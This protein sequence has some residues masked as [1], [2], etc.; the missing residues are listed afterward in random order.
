MLTKDGKHKFYKLNNKEIREVKYVETLFLI[1]E[2]IVKLEKNKGKQ[3]PIK[4]LEKEVLGSKDNDRLKI[5]KTEQ[6]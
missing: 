3:I 6:K 4:F 1:Y 2:S 5:S